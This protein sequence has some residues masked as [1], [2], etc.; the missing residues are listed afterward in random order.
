MRNKNW[1]KL[2][3][4]LAAVSVVTAGIPGIVQYASA[5][6]TEEEAADSGTA[7]DGEGADGEEE[8]EEE[9]QQQVSKDGEVIMENAVEKKPESEWITMK[10]RKDSG[11]YLK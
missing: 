7:S 9:P 5:T 1:K 4:L 2:I 8:E 11:V 6:G 3:A 10:D